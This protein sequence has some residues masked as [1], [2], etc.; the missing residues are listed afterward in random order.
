MDEFNMPDMWIWDHADDKLYPTDIINGSNWYREHG[1]EAKRVGL[2]MIKGFKISTV[3][4]T[5]DHDHSMQGP[6]ILF[7]TMVTAPD[8]YDEIVMR[9]ATPQEARDGHA[10]VVRIITIHGADYQ[11]LIADVEAD[12]A[13]EDDDDELFLLDGS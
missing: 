3:F 2:D 4:L 1:F 9:Y 11:R 7:E 8:G 12:V 5:I 6:P 10:L 13:D